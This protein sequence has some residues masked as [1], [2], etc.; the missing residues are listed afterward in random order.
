M[1]IPS[2]AGNPLLL[3]D[4]QVGE[5]LGCSSRHVRRLADCGRFPRPVKLGHLTRWLRSSVEAFVRDASVPG[6]KGGG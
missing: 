1:S 5:L 6:R 4:K 2:P 3:T